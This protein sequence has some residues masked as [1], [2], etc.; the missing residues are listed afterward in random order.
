MKMRWVLVLL[1]FP[2]AGCGQAGPGD[3]TNPNTPGATGSTVIPGNNSTI[4]GDAE[5]THIQKLWGE[6][7]TSN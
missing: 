7:G 4:A 5:A 1:A 2:L 3:P 6:M